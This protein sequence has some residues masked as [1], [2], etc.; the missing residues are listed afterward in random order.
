MASNP[1]QP[2]K[3]GKSETLTLTCQGC[4][5]IGASI[6]AKCAKTKGRILAAR[7]HPLKERDPELYKRLDALS[8]RSLQQNKQLWDEFCIEIGAQ[9]FYE[10]LSILKQIVDEGLWRTDALHPLGWL[11]QN[12]ARRVKASRGLEDY[13]DRSGKRR[14][15]G[16]KFDGRNG[17]LIEYVMRPFAEFEVTN[18]DGETVSPEEVIDGRLARKSL[19]TA[20]DDEESFVMPADENSLQSLSRKTLAEWIESNKCKSNQLL[21]EHE[22]PLFDRML[23][24]TISE[25]RALTEQVGLDQDEAEVLGVITLLWAVGPRTY[26]NFL[27]ETNRKRIRNA[28]DRFDRQLKKPQFRKLLHTALREGALKRRGFSVAKAPKS[29]N[30]PG[31]SR[32]KLGSRGAWGVPADVVLSW[33]TKIDRAAGLLL[34]TSKDTPSDLNA[35]DGSKVVDMACDLTPRQRALYRSSANK[36]KPRRMTKLYSE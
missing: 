7:A 5:K 1:E 9:R 32:P 17:A 21:L 31:S 13:D 2:N 14:P 12:L 28:W 29:A 33:H 24:R 35:N 22:L 34:P 36:P 4:G 16:P 11:R 6:C 25:Q 23:A 10:H 30:V 15:S 27:D 3:R 26:L 20:G 18:S 8:Q 19:C